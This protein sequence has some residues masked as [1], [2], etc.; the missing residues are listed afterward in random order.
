M[1]STRVFPP[2]RTGWLSLLGMCAVLVSLM[3]G[4]FIATEASGACTKSEQSSLEEVHRGLA[5]REASLELRIDIVSSTVTS[6]EQRLQALEARQE[7]EQ[8]SP[9]EVD[10]VGN[11]RSFIGFMLGQIEGSRD[12]FVEGMDERIDKAVPNELLELDGLENISSAPPARQRRIEERQQHIQ[13]LRDMI[14]ESAQTIEST[15]DELDQVRKV[16]SRAEAKLQEK[17]AQEAC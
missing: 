17:K 11:L 15:L 6:L 12:D 5:L 10:A 8:A 1:D 3:V 2:Q 4:F 16:K 9:S 7:R 13:A 14:H